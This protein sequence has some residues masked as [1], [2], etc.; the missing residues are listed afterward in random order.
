M[1]EVKLENVVAMVE[2]PIKEGRVT[3]LKQWEGMKAIIVVTKRSNN[4]E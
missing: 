2:K 3:G 1:N 4:E